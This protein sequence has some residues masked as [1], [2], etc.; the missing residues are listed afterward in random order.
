MP[1]RGHALEGLSELYGGVCKGA[2]LQKEHT[3]GHA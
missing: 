2:K 1:N 3:F